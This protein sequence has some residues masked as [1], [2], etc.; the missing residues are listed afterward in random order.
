[1]D[2]AFS[3]A[4]WTFVRATSA[5][6]INGSTPTAQQNST[7]IM[8]YLHT[9]RMVFSKL[10]EDRRQ[11]VLTLDFMTKMAATTSEAEMEEF[12]TNVSLLLIRSISEK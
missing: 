5:M 1:M 9:V 7:L 10:L 2:L 12:V 4:F 11:G 8:M 3:Q 6:D